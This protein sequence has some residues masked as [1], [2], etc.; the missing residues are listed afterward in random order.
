MR[1]AHLAPP[2]DDYEAEKKKGAERLELLQKV[3]KA[4]WVILDCLLECVRVPT[5][6][7]V[8]DALKGARKDLQHAMQIIMRP[9]QQVEP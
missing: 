3:Q 4:E 9:A 1:P 6:E 5:D 2:R 8:I 7:A